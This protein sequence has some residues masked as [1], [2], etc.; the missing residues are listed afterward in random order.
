MT[1]LP[2]NERVAI[3]NA[4]FVRAFDDAS[5]LAN[6]RRLAP[7]RSLKPQIVLPPAKAHALLLLGSCALAI[8]A[9]CNHLID[10]LVEKGRL[11]EE[12]GAAIQRLPARAK[13]FMLPRLA[14][15]RARFD[16]GRKPHSAI[17]EICGQRNALVHVNYT[18]LG[19]GIPSADKALALFRDFVEAME[20][21]NVVLRRIRRP[22]RRVL[23][24]GR[25]L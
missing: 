20:H 3:W 11:S 4:L 24:V 17:A 9:R 13:W 23:D 18:K 22:R 14:G 2:N 5:S 25:F 1:I 15:S 7:R 19:Q 10:D 16:P 21:L 8:E 6:L 12:E